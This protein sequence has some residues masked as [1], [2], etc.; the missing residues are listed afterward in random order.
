MAQS[1]ADAVRRAWASQKVEEIAAVADG[2][3]LQHGYN[4]AQ[5]HHMFCH[6]LNKQ[7]SLADFDEIMRLADDGYSGVLANLRQRSF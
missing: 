3:R 4:F 5:V 2:L 7:V 6:V 1:I